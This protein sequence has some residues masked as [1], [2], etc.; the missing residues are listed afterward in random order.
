[1]A[2][3]ST[4]YPKSWN[5][6]RRCRLFKSISLPIAHKVLIYKIFYR[7]VLLSSWYRFG[8]QLKSMEMEILRH[9]YGAHGEQRLYTMYSDIDLSRYAEVLDMKWRKSTRISTR[10]LKHLFS[11]YPEPE[12]YEDEYFSVE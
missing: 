7:P 2:P 12:L 5:W 10:S 8:S 1:M 11:S 9:I 6:K 4:K 3:S